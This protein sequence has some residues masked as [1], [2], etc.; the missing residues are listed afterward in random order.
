MPEEFIDVIAEKLCI[1]HVNYFLG[2]AASAPN[3][4]ANWLDIHAP[5]SANQLRIWLLECLLNLSCEE[6]EFQ[7]KET[8]IFGARGGS[9]AEIASYYE[10]SDSQTY[11]DKLRRAFCRLVPAND[12]LS[13]TNAQCITMLIADSIERS[14]EHSRRNN[15]T[16]QFPV[17]MT[18][19]FDSFIEDELDNRRLPYRVFVLSAGTPN[20]LV[21]GRKGFLPD[22]LAESVLQSSEFIHHSVTILKFH[23]QV[24]KSDADST[25]IVMSESDYIRYLI[26]TP[27]DRL[28]PFSAMKAAIDNRTC[29]F[30]GYSF[31][32]WNMRSLLRYLW[33]Y[34][35]KHGTPRWAVALGFST[36][37]QLLLEKE[38]GVGTVSQ[39][40][41]LFCSEIRRRWADKDF[42]RA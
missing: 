25:K 11:R 32:D 22:H 15:T 16:R 24:P 23:G 3:P 28:L 4:V 38:F 26:D 17:I 10:L 21:E 20:S 2:A 33:P 39:D 37:Q 30:L 31:N 18:T 40:L 6:G 42:N 8:A 13:N 41:T 34:G 7:Q 36:Y 29:L 9:L 1:G 12:E 5:P 27:I 14:I 35:I 19:N